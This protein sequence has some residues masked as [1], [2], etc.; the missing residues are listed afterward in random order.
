MASGYYFQ[1][2]S[3]CLT[4]LYLSPKERKSFFIGTKQKET[5]QKHQ[6]QQRLQTVVIQQKQQQTNMFSLFGKKKKAKGPKKHNPETTL[7][8]ISKMDATVTNLEKRRE[9]LGKRLFF[10]I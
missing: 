5:K 1:E 7:Q 4:A 2:Y 9:L 3:C 6:I 10:M 8:A